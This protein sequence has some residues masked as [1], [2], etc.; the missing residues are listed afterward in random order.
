MELLV[1]E[2]R[3]QTSRP[4]RPSHK[5]AEKRAYITTGDVRGRGRG[6]R[7]A[8]ARSPRRSRGSTGL[9]R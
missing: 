6:N 8:S 1:L 7:P 5:R 2:V 3:G 4:K 9:G